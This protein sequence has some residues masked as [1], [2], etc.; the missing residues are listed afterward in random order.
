MFCRCDSIAIEAAL[1]SK[2][3]FG[4]F[5]DFRDYIGTT[6]IGVNA[7]TADQNMRDVAMF[8]Q[9]RYWFTWFDSTKRLWRKPIVDES[10]A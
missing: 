8:D 4:K 9:R 2:F 5:H 6:F 1:L 7:R 10:I 3:E